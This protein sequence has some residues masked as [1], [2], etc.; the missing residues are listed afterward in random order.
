MP[1]HVMRGYLMRSMVQ[2][3]QMKP[4]LHKVAVP[5]LRSQA[6]WTKTACCARLLHIIVSPAAGCADQA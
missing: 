1:R 6:S 3:L 4:W 5:D 2:S